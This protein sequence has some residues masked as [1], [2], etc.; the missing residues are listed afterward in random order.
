MQKFVFGHNIWIF[1]SFNDPF[2]PKSQ[3][4]PFLSPD[5]KNPTNK[6]MLVN[7][8]KT[9]QSMRCINYDAHNFRIPKQKSGEKTHPTISPITRG[10]RR[11]PLSQASS[12]GMFR[13][14]PLC[15]FLPIPDNNG[16]P[17]LGSGKQCA[18]Q[19]VGQC[20][21]GIRWTFCA[22]WSVEEFFDCFRFKCWFDLMSSG[23]CTL[24][25]SREARD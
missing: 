2:H 14:W 16:W 5:G 15:P 4:W 9:A 25:Y 11:W 18:I 24:L 19:T 12:H 13:R 23:C 1:F 7:I 10:H 21:S 22:L 8:I 3:R 17:F 6:G 20:R